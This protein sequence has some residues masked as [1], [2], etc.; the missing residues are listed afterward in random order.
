MKKWLLPILLLIAGPAFAQRTTANLSTHG[1]ACGTPPVASTGYVALQV[2]TNNGGAT[3]TLGGTWSGTI[4][5]FASGDGATTWVALNVLPSNSTT[6]VTTATGNGTWQA[7]VAGYTQVCAAFTTA[8]SGTVVT[9]IQ[10]SQAS[11]RAGGGGG[12]G[13]GSGCVPSGS[14]GEVLLDSGSGSCNDSSLASDNGS[15]F[16]VASGALHATNAVLVTPNLG[17]PSAVTLTHATSLPCGA[18]P[19]LTGDTTSSATSCATTTVKVNGNT[20]GGTCTNQVVSVLSTSAVPT[21]VTITSAY[22]NN[23]IALTGTDINT[24]NQVV[25]LNGTSLGGL[26]SG[27]LYNTTSSGIPS[28]ATAA[29]VNTTIKGLTGCNTATYVYTPQAADCV[30]PSGGGS[31]TVNSGTSGQITYYASS[32]TAVSGNADANISNG[33]LTLGVANTTIG[34][35]ILEGST[36]GALTITPQATAGTPTWTAGTS[37]GT[38]AVTASSPLGITTATGNIT[39]ATCVVATA[40]PTEGLLRVAGSTQTATG[41]ELSGDATTSGSNAV[42]VVAL[43]GANLGGLGTGLLRNTTSTGVP[44]I[45]TAAQILAACTGCAPLASPTFTGTV[46]YPLLATTT[47][48]AGTGSSASPSVVS[49]SAAPS[50]SFSCATNASTATCTVNTTAVTANSNIFIQPVGATVIGTKIGVT[51]NTTADTGLVAPRLAAQ[52]ASTSFTINL[53]TFS[54]NPLCFNYWIVD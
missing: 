17:T 21:C 10:L 34:E 40:N 39:C 35:A 27:L 36:S 33:A 7:N 8:T 26:A 45:A 11:A 12:G 24:S 3:F 13:G 22:V 51:C 18:M 38:P 29:Q 30:A 42:T 48:C 6:A 15:S 52:V 53:G 46:T 1:A 32:G 50:G 4:S 25:G 41:A 9:T 19:A 54:T 28:I 43:N 31:G 49:C 14:S 37:S 2:G 47:N 5:F 20:P 16:T 23:S 44:T